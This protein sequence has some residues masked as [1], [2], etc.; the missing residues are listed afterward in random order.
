MH[1]PGSRPAG[2]HRTGE[3]PEGVGSID[4]S[5]LSAVEKVSGR[6]PSVAQS[7]HYTLEDVVQAVATAVTTGPLEASTDADEVQAGSKAVDSGADEEDS[8]DPEGE[9]ESE[10]PSEGEGDDESL[11][12]VS[13]ADSVEDHSSVG[14]ESHDS[15]VCRAA[16]CRLW[17]VEG[18]LR[19]EGAPL[20]R[21][22]LS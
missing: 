13:V 9:S 12:H 5:A 6:F 1:R 20:T 16:R 21:R 8:E 2:H 14:C 18:D 22:K 10:E 4:R 7:T 17:I 15:V 11:D 19:K 3:G